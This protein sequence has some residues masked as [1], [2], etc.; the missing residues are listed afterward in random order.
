MEIKFD[1]SE[2]LYCRDPQ[3]TDLGRRIIEHSILMI[4]ELG[5]EAF[6]FKK[7]ANSIGSTEKSIYRYFDNKHFLL[8]FLTSWYW[9]WVHYLIS[10]NTIN[11]K[12]PKKKFQIAIENLVLATSENTANSYI[13][14]NILHKVVIK[15]GGKAY[16]I[17]AV[18]DENKAGMFYSYKH[19]VKL[20][21]EIIEE[22]NLKFKYAVSLSSN[23]FEMANN[24]IYFAEHLPELSSLAP[25]KRQDEDLIKM[26]EYFSFKILG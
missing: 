8:L 5:F 2:G 9:E 25:G 26:L 3:G 4:D 24:Q 1:I 12:S 17:N 13:N 16:H 10:I 6:T 23:L 14:E 20:L 19:L 18:D 21:A 11:I 15:E 7:L 22:Y